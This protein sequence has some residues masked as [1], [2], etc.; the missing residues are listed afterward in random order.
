METGTTKYHKKY[1]N[2]QVTLPDGTSRT[3]SLQQ[4]AAGDTDAIVHA[5]KNR[6]KE[7]AEAVADVEGTSI[8]KV[9][10]ELLSMIKSVMTDQ[11]PTM[12]Q[13]GD[14]LQSILDQRSANF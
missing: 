14:R 10:E 4:L 1:Q 12:P 9:N 2:F 11:G 13:F 6:M 5:Y 8:D 7:L 3:L